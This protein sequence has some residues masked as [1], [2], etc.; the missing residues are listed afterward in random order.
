MFQKKKSYEHLP[1]LYNMRMIFWSES[2]KMGMD[3]PEKDMDSAAD[4]MWILETTSEK[5]A[6]S[7]LKTR[8]EN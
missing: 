8:R 6:I 3:F 5:G 4:L 2:K 7:I 1:D